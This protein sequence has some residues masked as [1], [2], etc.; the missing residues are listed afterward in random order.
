MAGSLQ[1]VLFILSGDVTDGRMK[2]DAEMKNGTGLGSQNIRTD[3]KFLCAVHVI[4]MPEQTPI[5]SHVSNR[6]DSVKPKKD[7]VSTALLLCQ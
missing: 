4:R 5:Q 6:I 7:T 3:I 1:R 2:R